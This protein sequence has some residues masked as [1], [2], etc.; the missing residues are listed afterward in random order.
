MNNADK[1]IVNAVA[2]LWVE[3]GGDAEGIYWLIHDI[4]EAIEVELKE[5]QND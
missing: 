5:K 4:K 3:L 1:N 2:K